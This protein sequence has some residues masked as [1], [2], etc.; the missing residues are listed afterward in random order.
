MRQ[1]CLGFEA[2]FETGQIGRRRTRGARARGQQTR[3]RF[4]AK[5]RRQ[6]RI[7]FARRGHG[8]RRRH[9]NRRSKRLDLD[10]RFPAVERPTPNVATFANI[11]QIARKQRDE[12]VFAIGPVARTV[13]RIIPRGIVGGAAWRV[14]RR[15]MPFAEIRRRRSFCNIFRICFRNHRRFA[16]VAAFYARISDGVLR[17][18]FVGIAHR[19]VAFFANETHI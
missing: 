15:R 5:K 12:F 2:L 8:R 6:A 19:G 14:E 17:N 11:F 10:R 3:P 1:I 4:A 7:G 16:F 18:F 9:Q 13:E